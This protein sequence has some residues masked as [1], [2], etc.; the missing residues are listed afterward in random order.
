MRAFNCLILTLLLATMA[1][2]LTAC[3]DKGN[4]DESDAPQVISSNDELKPSAEDVLTAPQQ[5][6]SSLNALTGEVNDGFDEITQL[7]Q[8]LEDT[9]ISQLSQSKRAK[10]RNNVLLMKNAI[11]E[12]HK[13][14]ADIEDDLDD[15][16][17][18]DKVEMAHTISNLRQQ[19]DLQKARI[20]Q[21]SSKLQSSQPKPKVKSEA[22]DS[23]Q[24][25]ATK[26]QPEATP[27][28]PEENQQKEQREM[29]SNELNECY[30]A[31]GTRSELKSHKI[32]DSEFMK[33]TKVMQSGNLLISY[34][35]KADKRTLN[36]IPVASKKV[37][38][39]TSHDPQS[40]SIEETDEKTIIKILN[41]TAFWE[42]SNY[43][44]VQV[45]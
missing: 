9:D 36:E 43:L 18:N 2:T 38:L 29:L 32:I 8:E 3:R 33:K 20:N 24:L 41:P 25:V 27:A 31:I 45:E 19:L 30:Y 1:T 22:P 6:K 12:K 39:I 40:Y 17:D 23:A 5:L 42:Y 10:L 44:V 16:E 7:E 35:T 21:L 15:L 26:K 11:Q 28:T 13:M 14:L 34:F 37:T 4:S